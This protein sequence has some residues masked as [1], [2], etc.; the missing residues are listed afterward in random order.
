MTDRLCTTPSGEWD[1]VLSTIDNA[2]MAS[3]PK[4]QVHFALH[5][6]GQA[7]QGILHPDGGDSTTPGADAAAPSAP[8]IDTTA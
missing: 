6:L 3:S 1:R 8:S 4:R 5:Q 2:D 7:F